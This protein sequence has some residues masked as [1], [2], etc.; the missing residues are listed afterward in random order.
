VSF[1]PGA[2]LPRLRPARY[3]PFRAEFL[4]DPYTVYARLRTETPVYRDRRF[5]WIVSR[6]DD[7]AA[8][9]RD[10][11][12]SARRPLADEPVPSALSAID[13]EVRELRGLQSRW[14]LCT[15]PPEHTRLRALVSGAFT[16][17]RVEA[18]RQRIQQVV[19]ELLDRVAPT[20]RME[21][22]ADFA[23]PLPATVVAELLGVPL[24]ERDAFKE[25]SDAIAEGF[26]WTE[27]SVRAAHRAQLELT[28]YITRLAAEK[29]RQPGDDLVSALLATGS[30]SDKLTE[31]ELVATCVMLLF[32]GHETT[33]FFLAN[34]VLALLEHP[35]QA[36]R[37]RCEP[38]LID[39]A[40][41]ELLRYNSPTQASFRRA[42]VDLEVHSHHISRGEHVLLL[43]G[44]ANRD[45]ARFE[46]PDRL[47]LGRPDN[48]HLAFSVGPH[49]C[50]GA[51]LAR[52]EGQ[53]G[54]Q[55]LLRRFPTLLLE[56]SSIE[57]KPNVFLR[58]PRALPI[59]LGSWPG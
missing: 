35:E 43:L 57:W 53:V 58:G 54:L 37:L 11:R 3:N 26:N 6:Y 20:G 23:Y 10:P 18:M 21:L 9:S 2:D 47:D 30:G 59:A 46:E 15:D 49:F 44:S 8:L 39:S 48:R 34:A 41:E 5:G 50:L 56:T 4:A 29:R 33:T 27:T 42:A 1:A 38:A 51:A 45:P 13:A 19:D 12:L 55:T 16:P 24:A 28:D 52:L 40:V 31:E 14:L 22:V 7:V 32:G 36:A 17:R 25:R